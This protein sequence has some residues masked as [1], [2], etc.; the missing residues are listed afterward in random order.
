MGV[1][2]VTAHFKAREPDVHGAQRRA[3]ESTQVPKSQKQVRKHHPPSLGPLGRGRRV[4]VQQPDQPLAI[5][6]S[7]G[8]SH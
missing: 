1:V 3:G 6:S 2:S 8:C 7:I 4:I 5:I